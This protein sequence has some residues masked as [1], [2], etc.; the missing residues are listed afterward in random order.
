M[1]THICNPCKLEA[2][3]G[4]SAVWGQPGLYSELQVILGYRDLV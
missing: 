2:E 3:A 1:V 4:G